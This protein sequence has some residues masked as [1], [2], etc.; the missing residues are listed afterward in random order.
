MWGSASGLTVPQI[1]NTEALIGPLEGIQRAIQIGHLLWREEHRL[2]EGRLIDCGNVAV[3]L[4][5]RQ[6]A[7]QVDG[8]PSAGHEHGEQLGGTTAT[9]RPGRLPEETIFAEKAD[10]S[11]TQAGLQD[12]TSR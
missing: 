3:D 5:V 6:R 8:H 12:R 9:C 7:P 10:L 4:A 2:R 11:E 1:R